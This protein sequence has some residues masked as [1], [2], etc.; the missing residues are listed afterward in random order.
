MKES[1]LL[2]VM[3][4]TSSTMA[5]LT[6]ILTTTPKMNLTTTTII[7]QISTSVRSLKR[8]LSFTLKS[9]EMSRNLSR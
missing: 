3:V 1:E 9:A 5:D 6:M 4:I 2:Q 7:I 8:R